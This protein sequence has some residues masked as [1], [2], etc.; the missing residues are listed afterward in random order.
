MRFDLESFLAR[1][2]YDEPSD[3]ELIDAILSVPCHYVDL[4]I[5][6]ANVAW[7]SGAAPVVVLAGATF[8]AGQTG[9]LDTTT[10]TYKLADA[11]ATAGII[12]YPSVVAMTAGAASGYMMVCGAGSVINIG[13]TIAKA[14]PYYQSGTPG[15]IAPLADVASGWVVVEV[16]KGIT[17]ANLLLTFQQAG[18]TF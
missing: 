3:Q 18:F 11:N 13:A 2:W 16:G 17:T 10:N 7:V 15:G 14:T 12:N 9:Y 4:V 8:T 5:T 6:A 1:G